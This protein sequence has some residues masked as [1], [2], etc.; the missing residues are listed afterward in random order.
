MRK[1]SS[2]IAAYQMVLKG[3]TGTCPVLAVSCEKKDKSFLASPCL[4]CFADRFICCDD[5]TIQ[6][7]GIMFNLPDTL[8]FGGLCMQWST[9]NNEC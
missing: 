2:F 1:G 8:S 4:V 6:V 3:V 7:K 5:G 9:E